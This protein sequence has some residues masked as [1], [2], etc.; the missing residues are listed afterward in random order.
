MT[1]RERQILQWIEQDPMISQEALAEKAGITRSSVAVHISNLMKKGYIAGKG[2]VLR[3]GTYAAV[4]GGVN[5]DIGGQS[6]A[7]LIAG[8]SNPGRVQMSLGG[9]GRNIAHNMALLGLDVRLLTAFG[10]D[11]YAQRIAASCGELGID[12][13]QALQVP[14][15]STSTYL[16]LNG[17]DGD[18][19]LAVSDMDICQ[20]LTP[21]FLASRLTLLNNAQ[22]IVADAN[23]P[24]ESLR[25][26]AESCMPPVF[27]DP[28]ST[29]KA[30]KLRPILGKI[31]TLKPN[32]IEAEL[33]SGLAITD[34]G[35]LQRAAQVLLDTGLRRVFISLGSQGVFAADHQG[36]LLL[37][38]RPAEPVNATGAGDAF[39]AGIAWAYLEGTDLEGTALA[40]ASAGAIAM[41]GAGTIN[42]ALCLASLRAR[43][44]L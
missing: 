41:E 3:S 10:D 37:P 13:S 11:L 31:H 1:Q 2:Y 28:V 24:A 35:S 44:K 12:I 26:L 4:V 8:D 32:R 5:M 15:G 38:C 43:M 40:G 42:P 39:M 6:Y 14:G 29:V 36:S 16:Y 25:F 21:Q 27:V 33:L 7:P 9:V 18:M 19:A 23:L 20:K 34:A 30:E 22:L 17:P